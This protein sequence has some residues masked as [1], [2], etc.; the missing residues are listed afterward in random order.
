MA[1]HHALPATP[2]GRTFDRIGDIATYLY[3]AAG[4][5]LLGALSGAGVGLT[6]ISLLEGSE[7]VGFWALYGGLFVGALVLA[8]LFAEDVTH[9]TQRRQ[10]GDTKDDRR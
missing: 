5:L 1:T 3:S 9:M 7:S 10:K 4:R 8:L 2:W 6:L